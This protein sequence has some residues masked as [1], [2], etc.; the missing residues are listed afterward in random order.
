[1]LRT[2]TLLIGA[3]GVLGMNR[4]Q[5]N[6]LPELVDILSWLPDK[7]PARGFGR[8]RK[9]TEPWIAKRLV[10]TLATNG[11]LTFPLVVELKDRP[12]LIIDSAGRA[13]GMELMELVPPSYAQALGI[14]NVDFPSGIVD[15]SV[16]TWGREW[17][18]ESIREHL[19]REGHRLSGDGWAG[20]AVESE[21]A[22]EVRGAI[23][24]KTE[25]LNSSGFQIL[26]EN[27]L[28]TYASTPGPGLDVR[29]AAELLMSRGISRS[30][31][32]P[33][34]AMHATC[35]THARDGER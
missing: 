21:W 5:A 6:S 27:W 19:E 33:N 9:H 8:L 31:R 11:L 2:P 12:D 20:D 26:E 10:A 16:F 14:A 4:I 30:V 13:I 29:V 24:K 34:N 3:L 32:M 25:R 18:S 23:D 17:N 28:G 35:E 1:M 22:A 15:R 7:V